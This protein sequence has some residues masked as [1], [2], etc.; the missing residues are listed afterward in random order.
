[1]LKTF[2]SHERVDIFCESYI[3]LSHDAE[4]IIF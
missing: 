1:M 4:S 2:A 3:Y